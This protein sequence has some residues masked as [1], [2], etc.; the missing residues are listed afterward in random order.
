M[1]LII[2]NKKAGSRAQP[3]PTLNLKMLTL[4]RHKAIL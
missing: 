4:K 3:D 2:V 1:K